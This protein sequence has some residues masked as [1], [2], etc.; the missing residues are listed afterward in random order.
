MRK[1]EKKMAGRR[2]KPIELLVMTGKKHLTREEILHREKSEIKIGC[3]EIDLPEYMASNKVAVKKWNQL[4]TLFSGFAF[5]TNADS[6]A[7]ARY[8]ILHSDFIGECDVQNKIKISAAMTTLEDRLFLN[9]LS[10]IKSIPKKEEKEKTGA[11]KLGL[12]KT[13][14]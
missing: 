4:K 2:G 11:E 14:A 3:G 8:C 10:R 5:V 6:D 1:M 13:W 12:K 9:P 7:V